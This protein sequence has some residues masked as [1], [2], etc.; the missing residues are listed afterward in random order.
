MP[1]YEGGRTG[2]ATAAA[3]VV[4]TAQSEAWNGETGRHWV[5]FRDRRE[6]QLRNF[7]PHL[8]A[9]ADISAGERVLDVGCGCGGTT[10]QAARRAADGKVLGVDLS[11]PMLAEARG[12]AAAEGIGNVV[13]EQADAQVHPF[14]PGG[15][16]VMLSRFGVMFFADPHAAFANIANA[17][18]PGG[19]LAFLC[20][21]AADA[22]EYFTLPR[23]AISPHLALP[24][25]SG[26][27]GEPGPY[28]LADPADVRSLLTGAGFVAI[29]ITAVAEPTWIG[30]DV[31]DAVKY[32]LSTPTNRAAFG[33]ADQHARDVAAAA[34]HDA[35]LPHAT[36]R[37]VEL[38]TA[39]WLVTAR[40]PQS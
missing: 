36:P 2:K 4:N 6:A 23:R 39:A 25:R 27:P 3:E 38:G 11:A 12:Q 32:Q 33:A 10:L 17:L 28:S 34:L 8:F 19:R 15:F 22:N 18:H 40:K 37:G 26:A 13:F 1:Q 24:D 16:D 21:Q 7:S 31:E 5:E 14:A 29:G 35:L 9:A 20:W 30:A